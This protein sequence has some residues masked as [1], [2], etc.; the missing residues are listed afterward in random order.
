MTRLLAITACLVACAVSPAAAQPPLPDISGLC[1]PTAEGARRAVVEHEGTRGIWFNMAVAECMLERLTVLP[2]YVER[3]RLLEDRLSITDD[4]TTL[5][6]HQLHMTEESEERAV[7]AMGA[8]R[9]SLQASRK[10]VARERSL[11]WVWFGAG[12]VV[13]VAIE[14]LAL[15]AWSS[16]SD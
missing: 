6:R 2:L 9:V 4:R 5:L 8:L 12:V 1:A 3:V 13:V 7:E 16:L 11:R 14:A 15:W 10:L